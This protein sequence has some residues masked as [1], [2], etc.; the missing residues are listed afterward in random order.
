MTKRLNPNLVKIHRSYTVVEAASLFS[1][2]KN[3]VRTWIRG[4]LP[5]C[6]DRRPTLILGVD[7]RSF[8]QVKRT[9]RKRRCKPSEMYCLRCRE[10]RQPAANMVDYYPLSQSTG[11]LT[12]LCPE[13]TSVMNRYVSNSNLNQILEQLDV[14]LPNDLE[15][16]S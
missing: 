12:G 9:A 15:H 13:C 8:L 1:V 2:H 11:R 5:V 10:P 16:I 6:D 7:L 3:T 14:Q 4:G